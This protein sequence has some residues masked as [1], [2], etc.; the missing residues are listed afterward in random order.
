MYAARQLHESKGAEAEAAQNASRAA[1]VGRK[2]PSTGA[3]RSRAAC[4]ARYTPRAKPP[5][6][7]LSIILYH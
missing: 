3:A 2:T 5:E 4:P 6:L 1:Y 7:V